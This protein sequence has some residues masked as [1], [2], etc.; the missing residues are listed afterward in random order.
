[1]SDPL[2]A[3]ALAPSADGDP[4]DALAAALVADDPAVVG[5]GEATHG[6]RET[7]ATKDRLLRALVAEGGVRTLALEADVAA[8]AAVDAFVRGG[9]GDV[10]DALEGLTAWRWRTGAFA[11]V[12]EWLRGYN[13]GRPADEQVRVRGLDLTDPSAPATQ[14]VALLRAADVVAVPNELSR[15]AAADGPPDEEAAR[16]GY[17]TRS[18][19]AA[20]AVRTR[21]DDG[22]D[23]VVDALGADGFERARHLCDVVVQNCEWHRVRHEHDG[24]HEAGMAA[25]DRHMAANVEW[26]VETDPGRVAVWAHDSHVQRGTFDDGTAWTDAETV[27]EHLA[28]EFDDG[29]RALGF[30]VGRGAVRAG[31]PGGDVGTAALGDPLAGTLTARLDDAARADGDPAAPFALAL[32][33]AAD[34]PALADLLAPDGQ[35]RWVGSAYDPDAAPDHHYRRTDLPASFDWLYFQASATPTRPL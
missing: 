27:G 35:V 14:L 1:M 30:D 24:P 26:C 20:T 23:A 29:Y 21:L 9:D 17:L 12:V 16:E 5:L 31:L 22:R 15:V 13:D 6:D 7:V 33:D 2:A 25:R 34:D 8:V 18:E 10:A 19:A 4:V 3:H 11:E 32:A 28:G